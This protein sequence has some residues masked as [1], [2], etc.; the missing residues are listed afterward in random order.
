MTTI[1]YPNGLVITVDK[2]TPSPG[3]P[4]ADEPTIT[5]VIVGTLYGRAEG[6][7]YEKPTVDPD[8]PT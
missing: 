8:P 3:I 1:S 2:G 4:Q 6:G 7:L 5:S